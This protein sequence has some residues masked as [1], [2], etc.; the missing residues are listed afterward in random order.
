MTKSMK[1][2]TAIAASAVLCVGMS[3]S[4]SA[5]IIS[6]ASPTDPKI[7]VP[8]YAT[9]KD[10]DGVTIISNQKKISEEVQEILQDKEQVKDILENAGYEVTED[11]EI[12]V[13]GAVD[14]E[15][16]EY[17]WNGGR[18]V[19]EKQE[20]PEGGVD[21]DLYLNDYFLG[22]EQLEN[23]KDGDTLYLLHQKADGTWE[24]LEGKVTVETHG[25][26]DYT[27]TNKFVSAHFDSLSPIA[28][29]KIMSNGEVVVL[30]KNEEVTGKIDPTK[31]KDN[32]GSKVVKTSS[33]KKSPK[34]GN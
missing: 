34:T 9:V 33:V 32:A 7:P 12:I 8:G 1:K 22:E 28:I 31:A 21:V 3:V 27:Y 30:D 16:G 2:L 15:I 4:A 25:Y 10:S 18:Y 5:S 29:V 19:F 20:V 26:G 13:M 6:G 17:K 23:L 11:Q 24:V 14:L